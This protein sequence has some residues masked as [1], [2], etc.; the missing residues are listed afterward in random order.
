MYTL[1]VFLLY[2][3]ILHF[4]SSFSILACAKDVALANLSIWIFGLFF[5]TAVAALVIGAV[6]AFRHLSCKLVSKNEEE[7]PIA[8]NK[9]D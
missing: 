3:H 8:P 7:Q 2:Q 6:Y 1:Y 4:I 5:G 9:E